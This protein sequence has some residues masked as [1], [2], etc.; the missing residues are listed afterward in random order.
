MFKKFL[1]KKVFRFILC[2]AITASFNIILIYVMIEL[3]QFDT[4]FLRYIANFISIEISLLFSFVVYKIWV[5]SETRWLIQEILL[6]QIPLYHLSLLLCLTARS[7]ILFPILD[8]L[9]I[10][11]VVNTLIGIVTSSFINYIRSNKI[12][13]K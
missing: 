6:R 3:L 5:W 2:G 11:F 1:H 12:V 13:F 7:L 4:P 8:W 10:H 9:K